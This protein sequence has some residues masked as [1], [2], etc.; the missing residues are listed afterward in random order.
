MRQIIA[1]LCCVALFAGLPAAEAQLNDGAEIR[2]VRDGYG[3]PHVYG[4]TAVDVAYGAGYAIT[5]DRMFQMDVLR[6]VAKG[7]LMEIFGPIP[8][9]EEA[10]ATARRLFYTDEERLRKLERLSPRLQDM[11]AAYVDGIND[12]LDEARTDPSKLPRE[13]TEL[14]VRPPPEWDVTDSLA[15]AEMLVETF[16]AGGGTELEQAEL[17]HYLLGKYD[18]PREAV[19]AFDDVRWINDPASP[20]TIP[21]KFRWHTSRSYAEGLPAKQWRRD[22]RIGMSAQERQPTGD[23]D[24]AA[25]RPA[26]GTRRQARLVPREPSD[27][28]QQQARAHVDGLGTL[29][30][31]MPFGS[32]AFITGPKRTKRN[33]TLQLGGPQVGQFAPQIIA[34]FGLHAPAENLDMTGLTFAGSGP[35]VLIGRTPFFAWTTTTGNSDGADIYV[36]QLGPEP[37]TYVHEGKIERM[38][39]RDEQLRQKNGAPMSTVRVCRTRNG[40]VIA[41]DTDNGV[42]Y[43]IRRSWFDMETGTIEGFFGANFVKSVEE[44]STSINKLQ[45]N[46]NMF[47]VDAKG[48]YG[49]WHPG[50]IPVRTAGTDVRLPQDG[51]FA[52]TS[53]RRLRTAQEMPHAV[54]FPRGWLANWNNKPAVSWDNGD[55]ANYGAVFRSQR[56]NQLLRRHPNMDINRGRK[57]NRINGTTELEFRFF[58]DHVVRAAAR[59]DDPQIRAAG[60]VLRTW[61]GRRRDNDGDGKVDAEPGYSLWRDW[62][63]IARSAAFDDDLG[64]FSS[65]SNDSMLLHVLDGKKASLPKSRDYLN[66]EGRTTFLNRVMRTNLD[67][68]A[69]EHGTDDMSQWQADM[70]TQHY[71]RLNVRFYDCEVARAG[72]ATAGC[73]DSRPG[74]VRPLDYMNRGTYNHLVEFTPG[75]AQTALP[76][77][78]FMIEPRRRYVVRAESIISPGQSGF[79]DQSGRQDPHYEDQHELY[80]SWVGKPMPL[81]EADVR[82]LGGDNVQTLSYSPDS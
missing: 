15:I 47:Y 66:G 6:A 13:Y 23:A 32:N 36:E 8:G 42:A 40:P 34:E 57:L 31:L 76:G 52:E 53:W 50:A 3:V 18:T 11:Y 80:A 56:W 21:R 27:E 81:R 63:S 14:G 24:G 82:Q 49:Y 55:G 79:I 62:R 46:H 17:L 68:L 1:G 7:R 60:E 73:D 5:Q 29:R 28:S 25:G 33:G 74:N 45:S 38:D 12:Y 2:I 30:K 48:N 16:G 67:A 44:F 64:E 69:D 72:G 61:T 77:T 59:S 41:T 54:N 51:R 19:R 39:C 10:D 70:P 71:T 65:R 43:A 20:V 4:A 22:A 35:A 37:E 26:I 75:S 78:G 58:R 9:F